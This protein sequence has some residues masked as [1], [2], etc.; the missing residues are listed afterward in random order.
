MSKPRH[1]T[2]LCDSGHTWFFCPGATKDS[3]KFIAL[4]ALVENC[5]TLLENANLFRGYAKFKRVYQARSQVQLKTCVLRHVSAHGLTSLLA[6]SSLKQLSKLNSHDQ[7]IWQAAYDEEYDGLSSLPTWEVL[8]EDQFKQM[9]KGLKP[10]PTTAIAT[11][12]YDEHNRPKRAKYRLVVLGNHDPH[13]W[14]KEATA[15]PVLSQLELRILTSL[16]V[17]NCHVSKNCDMK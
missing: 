13:C 9:S 2:L 6:P 4:P 14:S 11:I 10:L 1:G 15:A 8:T 5:Q 17:Y 16:A 3:S 12:K 7:S